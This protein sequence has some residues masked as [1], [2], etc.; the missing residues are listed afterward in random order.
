MISTR[1]G[2]ISPTSD[3]GS[4]M[5]SPLGRVLVISLLV[6]AAARASLPTFSVLSDDPGGWPAILSSIGLQRTSAAAAHIFVARTGSPASAEWPQRVEQGA[7]LIL[8]GES[9]LADM[10]G[11]KRGKESARFSSVA[12]VHNPTLS[13]VW[14]QSL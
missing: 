4:G 1:G 12:D 7:I 2:P 5:P 13:I 8:E 3:W 6:A 14:E 10:F 9:S 11:F